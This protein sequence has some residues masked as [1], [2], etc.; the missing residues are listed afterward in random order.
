MAPPAQH[1]WPPCYYERREGLF[2][3]NGLC[4][5]PWDRTAIAGGPLSA[6][7]ASAAEDAALE[8]DYEIARFTVDIFGKVPHRPLAIAIEALRDGRQTKLHRVTLLADERPVAQ[9]HVLRIRRLP[10]PV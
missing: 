7:L 6:L 3:P 5:S 4:R 1:R 9:A 10:T 2:V 8:A